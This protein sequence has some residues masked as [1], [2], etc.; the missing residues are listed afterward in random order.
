MARRV[1]L[2]RT[3]LL[4]IGQSFEKLGRICL[5]ASTAR[6]AALFVFKQIPHECEVI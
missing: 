3:I 6:T 2:A 4:E 1:F 5:V